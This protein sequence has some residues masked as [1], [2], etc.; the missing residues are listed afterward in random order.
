MS[1]YI[2]NIPSQVDGER[3]NHQLA[4]KEMEPGFGEA[5]GE[6]I[7]R[8]RVSRDI[9]GKQVSVE[10]LLSN[11]MIVDLDVLCAGMKHR[12]R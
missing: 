5:L 3:S 6:D 11:E 1:R 7:R 9:A 10:D 4:T 2:L 12:I 8:L